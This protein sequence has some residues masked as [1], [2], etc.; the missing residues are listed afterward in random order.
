MSKEPT[1]E[2]TPAPL[3]AA[4][5]CVHCPGCGVEQDVPRT[6]EDDGGAVHA[7][8]DCRFFHCE[9]CGTFIE[10]APVKI[11]EAGRG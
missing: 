6:I 5:W 8:A 11:V 10:A 4:L 9:E 3:R 7:E 2:P 1:D